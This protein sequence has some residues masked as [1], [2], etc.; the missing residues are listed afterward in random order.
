LISIWAGI[1]LIWPHYHLSVAFLKPGWRWLLRQSR[2]LI[3]MLISLKLRENLAS[4]CSINNS[5]L[6]FIQ[7]IRGLIELTV[8]ILELRETWV[9]NANRADWPYR[10]HRSKPWPN[11]LWIFSNKALRICI[12][13][14][15]LLREPVVALVGKVLFVIILR[16]NRIGLL[17]VKFHSKLLID[18]MTL[19]WCR[20]DLSTRHRLCFWAVLMFEACAS[21]YGRWRFFERFID[22]LSNFNVR[23]LRAIT[24]VRNLILLLGAQ[25]VW[26]FNSKWI[27]LSLIILLSRAVHERA[28]SSCN[29][30]ILVMFL[31]ALT[32][33]WTSGPKVSLLLRVYW[34]PSSNH[35]LL[36][37]L[38]LRSN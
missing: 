28:C 20:R 8:I 16:I 22:F 25:S 23:N 7:L 6:E 27:I 11:E 37:V 18:L 33:S 9:G 12:L 10:S 1:S 5:S 14:C 34:L 17:M 21:F 29:H 31:R 4:I 13:L 26:L 32:E 24:C 2:Q 3:L 36:C 15:Q 38:I 19:L 30:S 35:I